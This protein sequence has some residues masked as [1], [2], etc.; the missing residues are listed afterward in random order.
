MSEEKPEHQRQDEIRK[1]MEISPNAMDNIEKFLKLCEE[2]KDK[3]QTIAHGNVQDVRDIYNLCV[4]LSSELQ[5]KDEALRKILE[6]HQMKGFE[7]CVCERCVIAR[8]ALPPL[9]MS[10]PKKPTKLL[11][12]S[13]AILL[14]G[15]TQTIAPTSDGS[16]GDGMGGRIS[17]EDQG[18]VTKYYLDNRLAD[19]CERIEGCGQKEEPKEQEK[20]SYLDSMKDHENVY[21]SVFYWLEHGATYI[22]TIE[23]YKYCVTY[24]GASTGEGNVWG[25]FVTQGATPYESYENNNAIF[26]KAP[27]KNYWNWKK[28]SP[29][30]DYNCDNISIQ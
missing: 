5:R 23:E 28:V 18:Y 25:I 30:D 6:R 10:D 12:L 9:T 3:P 21:L 16:I 27:Q 7:Q 19:L 17:K 13:L 24:I 8:E 15:C 29:W 2:Q 1:I 20:L 11:L 14:S 4:V 22:V 26:L